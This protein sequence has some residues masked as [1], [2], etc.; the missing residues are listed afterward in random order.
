MD[1]ADYVRQISFRLLQPTAPRPAGFGALNKLARKAGLHLEMWMTVLPEEQPSMQRRLRRVCRLRR[2]S[3]FAIGAIINRGVEQLPPGQVFLNL[4]VGGGFP[5]LA[6]M[7]G[8]R[9]KVCIGVDRVA[10]RPSTREAFF[11]RFERW[12][13]PRHELYEED[14]RHYLNRVH[15]G[16]IGYCV[17]DNMRTYQDQFDALRL[18]EPFFADGGL[19]LVDDINRA[20]I[21]QAAGDFLT[22]S[23]F[24]YRVLLD[25]R[26]PR[27]GHPTFWN[28]VL[29]LQRG[30]RK[31]QV[32][33]LPHFERRV[34]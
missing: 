29:L 9:A 32:A 25:I 22:A 11:R 10:Q 3:T 27:S 8:H 19:V 30:G 12:K 17:S 20:E 34:A 23:P 24:E 16:S 14:F 2:K 21:R 4:G 33:L 18:A 6:A 28:G 15:Q 5:L 13:S 26:T 31:S 1:Y 7:S